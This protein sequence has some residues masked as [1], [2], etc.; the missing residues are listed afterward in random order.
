MEFCPESGALGKP[1]SSS[2]ARVVFNQGGLG[3]AGGLNAG[4]TGRWVSAEARS[5]PWP[6]TPQGL[7]RDLF[8]FCQN[9]PPSGRGLRCPTRPPANT[10]SALPSAGPAGP[11]C[12]CQSRGVGGLQA[13]PYCLCAGVSCP[14]SFTDIHVRVI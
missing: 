13:R 8:G 5:P 1:V 4:G 12:S 10:G 7:A 11:Q 14:Q 6:H 3:L 9:C 2:N